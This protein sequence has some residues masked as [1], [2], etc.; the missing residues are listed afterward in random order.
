M[1]INEACPLHLHVCTYMLMSAICLFQRGR[2]VTSLTSTIT[3]RRPLTVPGDGGTSPMGTGLMMSGPPTTRTS[4]SNIQSKFDAEKKLWYVCTC[5]C[6]QAFHYIR[7]IYRVTLAQW[8]ECLHGTPKVLSS[9][10]GWDLTFHNLVRYVS[11]TYNGI[12]QNS[13]VNPWLSRT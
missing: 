13:S 10:P 9:N 4:T 5:Y 7:T 6:E 2:G 3:A 8:L 12:D 1:H 11:V